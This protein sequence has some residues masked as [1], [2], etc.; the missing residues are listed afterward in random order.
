MATSYSGTVPPL[1]SNGA[2]TFS[3]GLSKVG[4]LPVA[5]STFYVPNGT[6]PA[7]N[8]AAHGPATQAALGLF[9]LCADAVAKRLP[10]LIAQSITITSEVILRECIFA[11]FDEFARYGGMFQQRGARP[12]GISGPPVSATASTRTTP[13]RPPDLRE[14]TDVPGMKNVFIPTYPNR[15]IHRSV[16]GKNAWKQCEK[17]VGSGELYCVGSGPREPD[18]GRKATQLR[19]MK[20][21]TKHFAKGDHLNGVVALAM[22]CHAEAKRIQGGAPAPYQNIAGV[23]AQPSAQN[24]ANDSDIIVTGYPSEEGPFFTTEDNILFTG[25]QQLLGILNRATNTVY[26]LDSVQRAKWGKN[27][28]NAII[29]DE[30]AQEMAARGGAPISMFNDDGT[31]KVNN[32]PNTI[33]KA[34]TEPKFHPPVKQSLPNSAPVTKGVESVPAPIEQPSNVPQIN[35]QPNLVGQ[36]LPGPSQPVQPQAAAPIGKHPVQNIGQPGTAH[37]VQNIGQPGTAHMVQHPVQNAG[38]V[39]A[40]MQITAGQSVTG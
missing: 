38:I 1:S 32:T 35:T 34:A 12:I 40:M 13:D 6:L 39:P 14:I 8:S 27:G 4:A 15:C 16:R 36:K 17:A 3:T 19:H 30:I 24:A 28:L 9:S 21:I 25:G 5:Q 37:M 22:Y 33:I 23:Q 20:L 7:S 18:H 26:P 29:N 31:R 11:E 10:G 2:Q